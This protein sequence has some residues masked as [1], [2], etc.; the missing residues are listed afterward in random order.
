[1]MRVIYSNERI[2]GLDGAYKNPRYFDGPYPFATEVFTDDETIAKAYI[3]AGVKVKR[4]NGKA[5]QTGRKTKVKE[6]VDDGAD[7]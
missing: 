2:E 3:A 4:L 7:N 1:M 5:W 6:G